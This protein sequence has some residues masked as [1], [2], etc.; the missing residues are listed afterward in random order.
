MGRTPDDPAQLQKRQY[1]Q[2]SFPRCWCCWVKCSWKT[3]QKYRIREYRVGPTTHLYKSIQRTLSGHEIVQPRLAIF[4][5]RNNIFLSQRLSVTFHNIALS[6]CSISFRCSC[7]LFSSGRQGL[8][9]PDT[10]KAGKNTRVFS[11]S[12]TTVTHSLPVVT[13]YPDSPYCHSMP[14]LIKFCRASVQDPPN[15]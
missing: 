6:C 11:F 14:R 8:L 1:A 2:A 4:L 10:N 3:T 15:I 12:H 9:P 5:P 13:L 7:A